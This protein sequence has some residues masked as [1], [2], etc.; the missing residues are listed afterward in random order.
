MNDEVKQS[1]P[2]LVWP[3]NNALLALQELQ[4]LKAET[5]LG[6]KPQH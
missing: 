2:H 5:L 1:L 4:M 3:P 6:N